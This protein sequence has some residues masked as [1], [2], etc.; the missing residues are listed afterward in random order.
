MRPLRI[1]GKTNSPKTPPIPLPR[2]TAN[3]TRWSKSTKPSSHAGRK[4]G[5]SAPALKDKKTTVGK[6]TEVKQNGWYVTFQETTFQSADTL[7]ELVLHDNTTGLMCPGTT[8]W[9]QPLLEGCIL[10]LPHFQDRPN[11]IVSISGA[12]L[13]GDGPVSF[14]HDG[15]FSDYQNKS[16][17]L[18]NRI[19]AAGPRLDLQI[20]YGRSLETALLEAGLSAKHWAAKLELNT[21]SKSM[22]ER[23]FAVLDLDETFYS[24]MANIP[25]SAGY[26]R[27]EVLQHNPDF[28]KSVLHA[29]QTNGEVGYIHN[30]D[31][32]RRVLIAVSS[33][34]SEEE[35][36]RALKLSAGAFGFKLEGELTQ[37]DLEVWSTMQTHAVVI[38]GEITSPFAEV[39]T[40]N[41]AE[42]LKNVNAY[43]K[44]T[45]AWSSQTVA[46]PIAFTVRYCSDNAPFASYETVEFAG[47]IP[48]DR[49]RAEETILVTGKEVKL[50]GADARVLQGDTEIDTDDWTSVAVDYTIH[51]SPDRRAIDLTLTMDAYE[52]EGDKSF[53]GDNTRI[54]TKRTIRVFNL[55]ADDPRLIKK[56]VAMP[57]TAAESHH[58][59]GELH[60]WLTYENG[61]VRAL[62]NI[63]VKV[64]A[65][66]RK[67]TDAQGLTA[68]VDFTVEIDSAR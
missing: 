68:V 13:E 44:S 32:G 25:N 56:V 67:D 30:V 38:G 16:A 20:A 50:T 4:S 48:V 65:E 9:T 1:P 54:Q 22:Q 29:M 55:A 5:P 11:V 19:V 57:M 59:R 60:N 47:Q 63:S 31:Y 8:V 36:Q 6:I 51:V 66:G 12:K 61:A 64:D 21:S 45:K 2:L 58:F 52:L 15:R 40:G 37:R 42:F 62:R 7:S 10:P 24:M 49:N 53:E 17:P 23:S 41:P 39:V 33:A 35:L 43:L 26:F 14:I 46:Q 18:I 28:A 34:A 3:P 27:P